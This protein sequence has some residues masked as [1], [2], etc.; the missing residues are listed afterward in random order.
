MKKSKLQLSLG[1]LRVFSYFLLV[2]VLTNCTGPEG[3]VGPPGYNG[4][5]G[6]DGI[7]YTHS[8]I[9]DVDPG[10]WSGNLDGYSTVLD[11]PEITEDIYYDGALLVYRLIEV[12]PKSFN[13]LPYTYVDNALAIYMDFDAYIGSINLIYKE[14]FDGVNDTPAPSNLMSFKVVII[15]G[16]P[17]ATLKTMVDVKD[18]KAVTKMFNI[19]QVPGNIQ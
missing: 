5:D 6:V 10:D 19:D 2:A 11:V 4:H 9:Y 12:D 1:M 7:N 8:V 3:P 15:E 18:Y 16:I 14:V 17:L 13:L